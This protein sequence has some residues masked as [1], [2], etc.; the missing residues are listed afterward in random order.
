MENSGIPHESGCHLVAHLSQNGPIFDKKRD[1]M[2]SAIN[3]SLPWSS[4]SVVSVCYAIALIFFL[5]DMGHICQQSCAGPA[6]ARIFTNIMGVRAPRL[7]GRI[8]AG[9]FLL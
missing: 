5:Q 2:R 4:F 1:R 7:V 8:P 9:Y 6:I 3:F